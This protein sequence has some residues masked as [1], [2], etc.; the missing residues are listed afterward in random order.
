MRFPDVGTYL[1]WICEAWD[2]I[3]ENLIKKSFKVCGIKIALAGS[4]NN[5]VNHFKSYGNEMQKLEIG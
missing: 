4:E 2:K 5:L 3:D 1:T